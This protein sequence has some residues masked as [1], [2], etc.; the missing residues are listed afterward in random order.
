MAETWYP[1]PGVT[2]KQHEYLMGGA[3]GTGVVGHPTDSSVVYA[4][5]SGTREVRI[6]A[7]KRAIVEGYGWEN[8]ASEIILS[9]TA[10]AAN[11][12]GST[13]VD[14]I[15]LRLDRA[16]FSVRVK[17]VQGTPGAGAPS[18]STS[19]GTSGTYELP[20]A[21]VVVDN[22]VTTITA[23]KVTNRAWYLGTDGQIRCTEALLSTVPHEAG[24]TVMVTDTNRYVVST[25]VGGSWLTAVEDSG[26][27]SVS[28]ASGWSAA[29][30]RVQ[31]LNGTVVVAINA[32]RSTSIAAGTTV[33][34]GDL[35]AG[36]WPKFE[37][38][39]RAGYSAGSGES[40]G[41]R[42]TTAGGIYIDTPQGLG[43]NATRALSGSLTFHAA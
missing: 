32:S 1:S 36:C 8:D 2:Q 3:A 33:K 17:V 13:R 5:G 9:G 22:N 14:L 42:A 29:L 31:R 27:L 25:G 15:V 28:L 16:D 21:E 43:I 39:G 7:S 10:I 18:P 38:P 23:G 12:S 40:V 30:N 19:T 35:P 26:L 24:R 37:V 41:L 6:R 4:P 11:T 34:L 20:L